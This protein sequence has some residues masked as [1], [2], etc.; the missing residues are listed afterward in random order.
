MKKKVIILSILVLA[1]ISIWGCYTIF[2]EQFMFSEY[3]PDRRYRIDVYT[4]R[5]FFSM[6]GQGGLYSRKAVVVLKNEHGRTI[7][8]STGECSVLYDS[9][10]IEWDYPSNRVWFARAHAINLS[11]GKCD[12]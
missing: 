2:A 6:P 1:G 8:K 10:E 3:S 9:I 11:T 7:G 12:C 4:E 5:N